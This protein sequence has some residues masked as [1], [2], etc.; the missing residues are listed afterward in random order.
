MQK[1]RDKVAQWRYVN[2]QNPS[3]SSTGA[4]KSESGREN[5]SDKAV[6]QSW[7]LEND[8]DDSEDQDEAEKVGAQNHCITN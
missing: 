2:R 4:M 1:R 7:S 5:N 6:N 3:E 8:E